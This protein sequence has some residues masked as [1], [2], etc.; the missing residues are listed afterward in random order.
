[1]ETSFFSGS[2]NLYKYLVTV[3]TL[4]IVLTV[5]YPLKEKQELEILTIKIENELEI[6]SFKI[7]DNQKELKIYNSKSNESISQELKNFTLKNITQINKQNRINQ[8][9][10]ENKNNEL[11]CRKSYITTYTW[12]F[13]IFF[14]IGLFL[15]IF[16]FIK[17]N[18]TKKIDDS[19]LELEKKKLEIEIQNLEKDNK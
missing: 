18:R 2:E 4:I 1:M 17:W 12:I 13:W 10:V 3:G 11:K 5:Y 6:L 15:I 16:G 14:P 8:I 7:I 9:S 19:I